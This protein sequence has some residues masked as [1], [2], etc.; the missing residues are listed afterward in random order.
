EFVPLCGT[1]RPSPPALGVHAAHE[2]AH[3]G[4]VL[5]AGQAQAQ[6]V[7]PFTMFMKISSPLMSPYFFCTF[8]AKREK[9]ISTTEYAMQITIATKSIATTD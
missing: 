4:A 2:H 6:L 9:A 5:V 7:D 3:L 8:S 1:C